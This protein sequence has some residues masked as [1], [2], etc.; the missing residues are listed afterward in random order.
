MIL[1]LIQLVEKYEMDIKGV[2]HI[3]AHFGEEN[4]A[5]DNVGIK[6]RAFFEPLKSNFNKLKENIK[7]EKY[8][9]Y[10]IALGNENKEIEM[11]VESVNLGQSCSV[12]K[13]KGHLI[14]YPHITF[15]EKEVVDMK[16]LDDVGLK[17]DNFNFINMD[18][19]GFEL[20]VLKGA[21]KT[22]NS[23][24]YIMS[25]INRAEV[26]ENCAQIYELEDFLKNYGFE[27]VEEDWGG[28]TWGD[29]FF[30]KRK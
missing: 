29:G 12:L 2:I 19:Q 27:L 4:P 13:P 23:I 7:D 22:L 6:N 30:I 5:Y 10:N 9:L 20:E 25:E 11:Y 24:D 28:Y 1:N 26:Y 17:L 15:N 21:E 3:G 14:Q 16:R 18:V 8:T